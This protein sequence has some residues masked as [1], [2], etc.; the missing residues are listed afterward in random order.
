METKQNTNRLD[1]LSSVRLE[2]AR[3]YRKARNGKM[4]PGTA[5]KHIYI[6]KEIR[7]VIEAETMVSIEERMARLEEGRR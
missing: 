3:I 6:L 2:M 7:G 5:T 4:E 1:K